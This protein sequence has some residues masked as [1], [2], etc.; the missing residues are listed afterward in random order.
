MNIFFI[1]ENSQICLYFGF[2]KTPIFLPILEEV[3]KKNP[4][5]CLS[6][7]R[8]TSG[9]IFFFR[10]AG[11]CGGLRGFLRGFHLCVFTY[12]PDPAVVKGVLCTLKYYLKILDQTKAD[13]LQ[14]NL[15]FWNKIGSAGL[16]LCEILYFC[17][18]N[19]MNECVVNQKNYFSFSLDV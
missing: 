5:F 15:Y 1:Y 2:S 12:P 13:M 11:D 16:K 18:N 17:K 4:F 8:R 19:F 6:P 3:L 14:K 9:R 10:C 7:I